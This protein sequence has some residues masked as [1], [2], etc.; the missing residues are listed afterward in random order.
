MRWFKHLTD[1]ADDEKL[2]DIL[3]EFGPEGYGVWWL[4]VE[5]IGKQMDSSPKCEASYSLDHWARKLYVS[6]RKTTSFLTVFSEKNLIFLEYDNSNVLG[7]IIVKIPKML[8]FRDEYSKKSGQPPDKVPTISGAR[9]QKKKESKKENKP[10]PEILDFFEDLWKAYPRKIGKP[11]ALKF[12]LQ[13]VKTESDMDSINVALGEYLAEV[14][15]TEM[16]YIK[17]GSSWFNGW[18][19][20]VA[21]DGK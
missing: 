3:T 19:G 6:K 18:K 20:W 21:N 16:K 4:L 9:E 10:N 5:V 1:A 15:D 2:A 11:Q 7:K 13:T 8:N 14:K 12:Y 17:H